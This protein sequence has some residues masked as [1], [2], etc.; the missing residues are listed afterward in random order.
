MCIAS[1]EPSRTGLGKGTAAQA[2][3]KV[4]LWVAQ[5]FSAAIKPFFSSAALAAEVIDP[6][7]SAAS[8][9]VLCGSQRTRALAPEGHFLRFSSLSSRPVL[10]ILSALLCSTPA[11][12]RR[13]F[14]TRR[15]AADL[16]S[17]S[18]TF[19]TPQI[20]WL[21]TGVVSNRD[22]NSPDSM[23]VRHRGWT[24]G[25]QRNC[26][27]GVDPPPCWDVLLSPLGVDTFRPLISDNSPGTGSMSVSVARRQLVNIAGISKAGAF[28]DVEF[29]WRWVPL[30]PVGAAL[31]D[32][33]VQYR[34]TVGF[35]SYDDG[36]RIVNQTVHSNQSLEEALRNAEPTAP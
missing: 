17:T 27:P 2:A 4:W 18:E 21:K 24:I 22:F 13:D 34:S 8:S 35:R 10:I 1:I 7:F 11:C 19:K 15:L 20:F 6:T 16:I 26:P 36:W 9:A 29:T 32:E 28:A 5:R 12:S 25:T 14:L 3:V 30:N 33:G 31:Y 23:V